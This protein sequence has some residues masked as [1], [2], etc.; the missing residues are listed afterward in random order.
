MVT[1]PIIGKAKDAFVE[2]DVCGSKM[3]LYFQDKGI[4]RELYAFG[5]RENFATDLILNKSLIA[6]E[7]IVLDIGANIGYY[8]LM[9]GKAVGPKGKVYAVEP[10]PRNF[11][12]LRENIRLNSLENVEAFNFALGDKN[13]STKMHISNKSNWSR[14][15]KT[16]IPDKI[17]EIIDVEMKTVDNFIENKP[18]P[19]FIRMDVEGY[20]VNILR[21]M[22]NLIKNDRL[23][24][25]VE[26][27]PQFI[28]N[29][30]KKYFFDVLEGNKFKIK[31]FFMNPHLFQNP[32]TEFAYVQL[33][34]SES[35]YGKFFEIDDYSEIFKMM[36]S[37]DFKRMPHLFFQKGD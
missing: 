22:E 36:V 12:I 21:G 19:S 8:A 14:V 28:S 2:K 35:Y 6:P 34:Q 33:N 37:Y 7:Q 9:E 29:E 13:G 23:S 20:E 10:V 24:I 17:E 27:H 32:I 16:N 18:T 1:Y 4:T 5:K 3:R 30:D 25:F 11:Q 31:Y 15:I 26:F